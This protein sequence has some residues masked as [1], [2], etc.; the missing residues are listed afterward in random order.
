[1]SLTENE[2]LKQI[3]TQKAVMLCQNGWNIYFTVKLK[4]VFV[5]ELIC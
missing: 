1:M 2:F 3:C 5:Y 4:K